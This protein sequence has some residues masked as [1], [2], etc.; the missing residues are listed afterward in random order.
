MATSMLEH[1]ARL[2]VRPGRLYIDGEWGEPLAG[3]RWAHVHP[4]TNEEITTIARAEQEDVDRAVRSARRAFDEGPWPHL[5]ARERKRLLQPLIDLVYANASELS[6]LQTLDNGLPVA[7]GRSYR[8]SAE[9]C[10]DVFDH[11]FG[12]ID[13]IT[14]EVYPQFSE[15]T[16]LQYLSFREPVGVVAGINPWNAPLLQF[17]EKVGPALATGCCIVIKPS[18]YASLTILRL[19]ELI[20]ELD[21]PPGVL[22]VVTGVGS[23]AG[24]ALVTHPGVDKVSFTGSVAI[25]KHI[26]EAGAA[27]LKRVTLELGGKSPAIVF[28][29]IPEL[30]ERAAATIAGQVFY[31]LSGQ[32]CSAQTRAIVHESGYDDFVQHLEARV[33]AVRQGDPFDE[34]TTSAPMINKTQLTKVQD[35]IERGAGDGATILLGG[36]EPAPELAAGNWVNPTVFVDVPAGSPL[37]RDEI[38]GPVLTVI[39][40][41]N[42]DEAVRIANQSDYGLA[43]GLYTADIARAHRVTRALR[44]GAVGVNGYSFMPNSPFGGVKSSGLGREGGWSS[45]EEFTEVKTMAVDL[46]AG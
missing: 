34:K 36:G 32:V 15:M 3:K 31:G 6:D 20:A 26:V 25:G 40:F 19:T 46:S 24:E 11:Y 42:E 4:A 10:A 33:A 21:L 16:P 13:K 9:F 17:P 35:F 37:V 30:V 23:E 29:D 18:E 1:A 14:G 44:A 22:N 27:T 28:P 7:F 41:R 39:P 8:V 2:G 38:F 12:W 43:A 45:I 5:K